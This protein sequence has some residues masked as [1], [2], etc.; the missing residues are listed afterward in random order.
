MQ[1]RREFLS[2]AAIAGLSLPLLGIKGVEGGHDTSKRFPVSLFSKPLD[3]YTTEFMCECVA[4]AGISGL[5]L[6]VR[7][8]G[9]IEPASVENDLPLFAEKIKKYGLSAE[10]MVTSILDDTEEARKILKAASRSGITYYRTGWMDYDLKAGVKESLRLAN[11]AMKR[12]DAMNMLY[13]IKSGYQNHSGRMIGSPVW[14]LP[15][16]L[17]GTHSRFTGLQYDVR[18]AC[19][20][21]A[22]SWITGLNLVAGSITSL[23]IKDYTWKNEGAKAIAESVPLGEGMVDWDLFFST[24]KEKGLEC[25]LTLHV[26]YPL[27]GAGA[28]KLTLLQQQK[29]ITSTLKRDADFLR[30]NLERHGLI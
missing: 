28:Q 12:I 19:V 16:L 3:A 17:E 8:E 4:G 2:T 9:K 26:E 20:E 22:A 11:E 27:L 7:K 14:D 10:M 23:A 15:A 25:P 21:G 5:D 13:N 6:T 1:T 29:I 18:H 24:I 30:S